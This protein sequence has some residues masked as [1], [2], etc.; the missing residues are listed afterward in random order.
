MHSAARPLR[1]VLAL[2]LASLVTSASVPLQEPSVRYRNASLPVADRVAD[3]LARMTIEE[4][5]AQLLGIWQQKSQFQDGEGVF[6]PAK[7]KA[8]LGQGIGQVSRPSEIAGTPNG[9]RGRT[10]RQQAEYTNAVQKWLIENTR[11]GIPAMFHEEALH[12]LAAPNATH[13]PVPL[14]LGKHVGSS[15]PR[16]R[17]SVAAKEA[18][19]RGCQHVLAPVVDLA[20]DPRWGRVEETYGE[21]PYLVSES[22]RRRHPRLSGHDAAARSGESVRDAE[23]LCRSRLA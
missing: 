18:R 6:D 10:P 14:G 9:P 11:L 22:R 16:A 1:P 20:R 17:M 4:K 21:D 7:A 19:A 2:I 23:T 5:V 12:G 15:A 13:F 3:L 8:F